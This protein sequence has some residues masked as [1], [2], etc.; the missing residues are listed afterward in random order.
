MEGTA[1]RQETLIE[2]IK[3]KEQKLWIIQG[4]LQAEKKQRA[5]RGVETGGW[6]D[7]NNGDVSEVQQ[8]K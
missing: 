4:D 5:E 3:D 7:S 6:A 8:R 2:E 1:I